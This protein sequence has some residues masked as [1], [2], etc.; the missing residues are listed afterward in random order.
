MS[1]L[2]SSWGFRG[3]IV[4]KE[5]PT[6][7]VE[8]L[9]DV[10]E[11]RLRKRLFQMESKPLGLATGRTMQPIYTSLVSRLKDW[12]KPKMDSLLEGWC[13]FNL[14][15]YVGLS[16]ES[17]DSFAAFMAQFL[18]TPLSLTPDKLRLPDGCAKDPQKEALLYAEQLKTLGGVGIQLLGLGVNGHVGFNEPPCG[19]DSS[20]RVVSLSAETRKQ[21]AFAFRGD[22]HLV[23]RNAITLGMQEILD[24][25]EIHLVVTGATK[26]NTLY[27]LLNEPMSECLPAS[28]IKQ[29]NN[30]CL[31]CDYS[32]L[33][34]VVQQFS[35]LCL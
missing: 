12:P 10:L 9:V 3:T 13:S 15:E 2:V 23:P 4:A 32:S 6:E 35:P 26:A 7:L 29:H 21:N 28:W 20:C 27:S 34:K 30:I 11:D 17:T 25:E 8:I 31:W 5:N 18:G 19:S 22:P 1:A 24:A 14:D 33:T 16:N